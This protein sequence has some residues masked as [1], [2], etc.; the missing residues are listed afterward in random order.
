MLLFVADIFLTVL[1]AR[2]GT[3]LLAP[4]WNRLVLALLSGVARQFGR[5]RVAP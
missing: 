3:G 1:Y 2:A 5:Y 4:R